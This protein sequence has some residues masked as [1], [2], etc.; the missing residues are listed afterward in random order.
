MFPTRDSYYVNKVHMPYKQQSGNKINI[1][2]SPI[3]L[4][5]PNEI[6]LFP[7]QK[8]IG[9][10]IF[11][12]FSNYDTLKMVMSQDFAVNSEIDKVSK[13]K[14]QIEEYTKTVISSIKELKLTHDDIELINKFLVSSYV[15]IIL[16]SRDV[17]PKNKKYPETYDEIFTMFSNI[18]DENTKVIQEGFVDKSTN[19]EGGRATMILPLLVIVVGPER[20]TIFNV[21]YTS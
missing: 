13:Q 2:F 1:V 18:N 19:E 15:F 6:Q 3:C 14:Q 7:I 12:I 11:R 16:Q 8:D 10:T 5:P 20:G 9:N 4:Y 17:F 21:C